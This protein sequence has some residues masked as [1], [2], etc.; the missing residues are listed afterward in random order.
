MK[1]RGK[2]TSLSLKEEKK[3]VISGCYLDDDAYHYALHLFSL[4]LDR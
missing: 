3:F 1:I 2:S 4:F